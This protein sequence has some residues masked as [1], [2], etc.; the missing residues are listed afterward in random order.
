MRIDFDAT[1]ATGT[2]GDAPA[3]WREDERDDRVFVGI[4]MFAADDEMKVDR[5]SGIGRE[6]GGQSLIAVNPITDLERS[7]AEGH[8]LRDGWRGQF[9]RPVAVRGKDNQLIVRPDD[10]GETVAAHRDG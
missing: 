2:D 3:I 6:N 5:S 8:R 4:H 1:R 7:V 10:D 9:G